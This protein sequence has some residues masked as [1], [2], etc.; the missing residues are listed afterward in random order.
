[1]RWL[2][3]CLAR[4]PLFRILCPLTESGWTFCAERITLADI[5]QTFRAF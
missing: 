3:S 1:L 2:R 4:Q 5:Y